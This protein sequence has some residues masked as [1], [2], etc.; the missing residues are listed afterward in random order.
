MMEHNLLLSVRVELFIE[1]R[2]VKK[3]K[4]KEME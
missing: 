3:K 2:N 4:N 1:P